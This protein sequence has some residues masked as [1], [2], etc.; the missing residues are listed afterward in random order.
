M[1]TDADTPTRGPVMSAD[2]YRFETLA[3]EREIKQHL[4]RPIANAVDTASRILGEVTREAY[5]HG[6]RDGFAQGVASRDNS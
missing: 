2:L 5:M 3:I 1:S 6:L 4:E